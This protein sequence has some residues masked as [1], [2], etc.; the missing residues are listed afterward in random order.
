M[1]YTKNSEVTLLSFLALMVAAATAAAQTALPAAGSVRQEDRQ[2][3]R[4]ATT[5]AQVRVPLPRR[6]DG[7][8]DV[9]RLL[10]TVQARVA[11]GFR[12][13]Q[14]RDGSLTQ[15]EARQLLLNPA[16]DQNLLSQIRKVLPADGIER[17]VTFRG[18][19][20]ARVQRQENGSLRTRIENINVGTLSATERAQ[21]AQR[22]SEQT[23]FDRIRI[24]GVDADGNRVRIESRGDKGLVRN[25]AR[26]GGK[27]IAQED[28]NEARQ[29]DRQVNRRED[30][31]EDRVEPREKVERIEQIER[32]ERFERP[33]RFD[34]PSRRHG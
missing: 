8:I 34:R 9:A 16:P 27:S 13:I 14:F 21:L 1:S 25:G 20:E 31:R 3:D 2:I 7:S 30:L 24:G 22:L 23:G 17:N 19:I 11:Q 26:D 6:S 29:E 33:E 4:A 12:E 28:R 5:P 10:D 18:A 32:R 15:D